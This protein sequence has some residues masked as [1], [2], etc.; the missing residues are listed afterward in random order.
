[1]NTDAITM[2]Q[3]KHT[4]LPEIILADVLGIV[5]KDASLPTQTKRDLASAV[6]KVASW[7]GPDGLMQPANPGVLAAH[8]RKLSPAMTGVSRE[9][10]ANIR[11]RLRRAL[12]LAG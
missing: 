6:R 5:E 9:G 3:P 4:E 1:M 10:M 11:S 7:V 12:K 2:S 8:I